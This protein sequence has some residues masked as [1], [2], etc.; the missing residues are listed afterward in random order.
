MINLLGQ[1]LFLESFKKRKRY[2]ISKSE[3]K[4]DCQLEQVSDRKLIP[5]GSWNIL[6]I[7][8]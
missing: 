8:K 4:D 1:Y 2:Q 5:F 3:A 6:K 7:K